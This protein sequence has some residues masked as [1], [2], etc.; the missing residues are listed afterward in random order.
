MKRR[1]QA[2]AFGVCFAGASFA[3]FWLIRVILEGTSAPKVLVGS[4]LLL[5][6]LVSLLL[7]PAVIY[8]AAPRVGFAPSAP[9]G[10]TLL[11]AVGGVMIGIVSEVALDFRLEGWPLRPLAILV[12]GIF[13]AIGN[14]REPESLPQPVADSASWIQK[15]AKVSLPKAGCLA[16][17]VG[18]I[19]ASIWGV[20]Q[21]WSDP[22]VA[23]VASIPFSFAGGALLALILRGIA[24][25][26]DPEPGP[27]PPANPGPP[28]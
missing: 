5:A 7:G 25:L 14:R 22:G 16:S 10:V 19:P 20:R 11:L 3:L 9:F 23:I 24:A 12:A 18:I 4:P 15:L 27:G 26:A 28:D 6:L 17:L 13:V 21:G 2:M 1:L 8:A